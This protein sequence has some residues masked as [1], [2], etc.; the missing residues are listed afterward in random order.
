MKS[1]VGPITSRTNSGIYLV[2]FLRS[3]ASEFREV[4]STQEIIGLR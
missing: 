4:Q 3:L 2:C 1:I